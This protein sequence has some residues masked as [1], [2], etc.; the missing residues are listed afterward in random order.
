MTAREALDHPWIIDP[1]PSNID[2]RI[3]VKAIKN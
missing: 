2:L 1:S 3:D